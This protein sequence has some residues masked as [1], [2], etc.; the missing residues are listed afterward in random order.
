MGRWK[1]TGW[2]VTVALAAAFLMSLRVTAAAEAPKA[3]EPTVTTLEHFEP[4]AL[5]L[6]AQE[7]LKGDFTIAREAPAIDFAI[8]PGQWETKDLWSS[9]GDALYA[10]DGKFY[11]TIGDHAMWGTTYVYELDPN[12]KTLRLVI[13]VDKVL[14]LTPQD[15]A[16]GKIHAPIIDRGDGWL[17]FVNYPGTA[18]GPDGSYKG[19][20]FFRYKMASGKVEHLGVLV[21]NC[22]VAALKY[23]A[24]SDTLYGLG[25]GFGLKVAPLNKFFAYDLEKRELVYYGG[26][27]PGMTRALM[28]AAD[29]RAY[30]GG[31]DKMLQRYDPEAKTVTP[32]NQQIPG[33]G[34]LR[35][36]SRPAA[37]GVIYAFSADGVV[38]AFDPKTETITWSAR[39]FTESS[40]Y[41]TTCRLDLTERYLYYVPDADGT[42]WQ[43]GAPV[44]QFDLKTRKPKVLASLNEF[45][46][47]EKGCNLGGTYGIALNPDGTQLFVCWNTSPVGDTQHWQGF[48]QCSAMI[49]HIPQSERSAAP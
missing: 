35:A 9:W 34:S 36:V 32:I 20:W 14:G 23:H 33:D 44:I 15:Y 26:P 27:E 7:G 39:A 45:F 43:C 11:G 21:A 25:E 30:Y 49:V 12:T 19:D 2:R 10:S 17:Y 16:A 31:K 22:G 48:G 4:S 28:V 38:F 6:K 3:P 37:D 42:A 1:R 40:H 18:P 5:F 46:V 41:I 47:K 13:D 8:F 29:G 24:P